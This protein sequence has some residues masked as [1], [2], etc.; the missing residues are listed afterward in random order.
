MVPI[1][2]IGNLPPEFRRTERNQKQAQLDK[3]AEYEKNNQ[4]VSDPRSSTTQ[5]QVNLSESARTLL[6]R[7]AEIQRYAAEV[8]NVETLSADERQEIE[9]KISSGFYTSPEVSA[10]IA[11]KIAQ[12]S[13]A[14]T[15]EVS[16][17]SKLDPTRFQ[18]VIEN[19]RQNQYDSNEVLDIISERILKDL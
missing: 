15:E 4:A 14:G 3:A 2:N 10:D 7:D 9:A 13:K 1:K 5:D 12:D 6:Q 19:I 11:G 16:P 18:E 8:P 17:D